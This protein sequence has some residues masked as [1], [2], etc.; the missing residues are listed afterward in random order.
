MNTPGYSRKNP[1]LISRVT[2]SIGSGVILD[3]VSRQVNEDLLRSLRI[4]KSTFSSLQVKD[5]FFNRIQ[6]LFGTPGDNTSIAHITGEFVN[7]LESLAETPSGTLE[8]N[9]L[10]RRADDLTNKIRQMVETIQ[11]LRRQVD[12][13]IALNVDEI[14]QLTL[15][16]QKQNAEI[17]SAGNLA[18]DDTTF[19][20]QR[21]S[22]LA[23]LAELIDI[24]SFQRVNGEIVVFTTGGRT[25]VDNI[26]R[27]VTHLA[28]GSLAATMTKAEGDINGIFV[29]AQVA[30]NDI[31]SEIRDGELK[32][33]IELRDNILTDMQSQLDEFTVELKT[34]FNQ[35][36]NRGAPQPGMQSATGTL[37]F[38]DSATQT[39][40]FG[41]TDDTKIIIVD[42]NGDQTASLSL[43]TS[44][45]GAGPFTIDA[46]ATAVQTFLQANDGGLGTSTAAVSS[47]GTF[48]INLTNSALKFIIR[49][50]SAVANGS[51]VK[52]ASIGFDSG[53]VVGTDETING[54][55]NFLGLNDFFV[56]NVRDGTHESNVFGNSFFCISGNLAL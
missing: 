54:F 25:L 47:T 43:R 20:D 48:D 28:A 44:L 37:R 12:R 26:P 14:N 7:A 17:S 23:R 46:V 18:T 52:D 27:P 13:D 31:T 19:R 1:N 39:I 34:A 29:G 10:V 32:G 53:G 36:H 8:H 15:S 55:S 5:N 9:E 16:I 11:E 41:G 30:G 6:E 33:L 4:E 49:D 21:D 51:S 35:I 50:E 40:T 42:A 22:D 56:D 3:G 24:T 2:G 38:V 45:G